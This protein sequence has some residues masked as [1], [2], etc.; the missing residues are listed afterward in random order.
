[1]ITRY[2]HDNWE[3]RR[4]DQDKWYKATVPGTVYTDL[5]D[6]GLM[7]DPYYRDNEDKALRLMDYDYEYR[8]SFAIQKKMKL[9]IV[10]KYSSNL[11]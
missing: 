2:L 10:M 8:M 1:M 6:N 11:R 7:E 3:M 4:T 5:L 9:M